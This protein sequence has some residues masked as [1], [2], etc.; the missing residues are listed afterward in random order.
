V[1]AGCRVLGVLGTHNA[2]ELREAGATWIVSS[3]T[4]VRTESRDGR[5]AISID[6]I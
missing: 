6:A 5:I 4:Q 1:A 2:E 3:L